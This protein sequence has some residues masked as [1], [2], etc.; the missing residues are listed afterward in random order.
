MIYSLGTDCFIVPAKIA[1]G[2][3]AG[4]ALLINHVTNLLV[5]TF[6]LLSNLPLLF[7]A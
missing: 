2:G 4:I 6:T 1:P 3:A 7:L 5:G